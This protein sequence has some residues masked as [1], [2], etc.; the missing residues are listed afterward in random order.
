MH[1]LKTSAKVGRVFGAP[2]APHGPAPGLR[3]WAVLGF[4]CEVAG[5]HKL[6]FYSAWASLRLPAWRTGF[7]EDVKAGYKCLRISKASK[8]AGALNLQ[9]SQIKV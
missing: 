5:K 7:E 8:A 6:G 1:V 3:D 2:A 4:D 9:D